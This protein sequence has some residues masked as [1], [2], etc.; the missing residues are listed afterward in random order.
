VR[1]R[2]GRK[3]FP[4][5]RGEPG[6]PEFHASYDAAIATKITQPTGRLSSILQQ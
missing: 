6:S 2:R 5:L 4:T 1:R 3:S